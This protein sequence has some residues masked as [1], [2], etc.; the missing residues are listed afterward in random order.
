MAVRRGPKSLNR[1]WL[2]CKKP[3]IDEGHEEESTDKE[4]TADSSGMSHLFG[5]SY[6]TLHF[7]GMLVVTLFT[8]LLL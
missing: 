8:R 4:G 1:D 6:G 2:G 7:F 5:H 3:V